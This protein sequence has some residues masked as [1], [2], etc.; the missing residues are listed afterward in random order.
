M[1]TIHKVEK[2][3]KLIA[4]KE[5]IMS[6]RFGSS[7]LVALVLGLCLSAD[8]AGADLSPFVGTVS[9]DSEANLE[10]G[11]GFGVRWG[12]WGKLFGGET[13][14]MVARPSREVGGS[15]ETATALFYEGR[16][17]LSVPAGQLRPFAGVGFGA[18]TVT[19]TD[20]PDLSD[21][22]QATTDALNAVADAST[23]SAFSYGVGVRYK[24]SDQLDVRLD[25][26]QYQVFS[27]TGI[28]VSQV[29]EQAGLSV[30]DDN[31]VQYN[32]FSIGISLNF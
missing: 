19:S 20:V 14:V 2:R 4:H 28:A 32:E 13:A 22:N 21:A 18:V 8:S 27:V 7:V 16:I 29:A 1:R 23:N 15:E 10:S 3:H 25:V 17:I 26:R 12:K 31:T 24:V 5:L 11:P 9:F 30:E 6:R